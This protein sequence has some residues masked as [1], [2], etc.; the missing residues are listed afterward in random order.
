MTILGKLA[1]LFAKHVLLPALIKIAT[2]PKA[3]LSLDTA[4]DALVKAAEAEAMRQAG[5]R[6]GV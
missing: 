4:K 6:L 1:T 3:P 5:K 2:N